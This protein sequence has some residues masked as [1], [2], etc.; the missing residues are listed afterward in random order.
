MIKSALIGFVL[1]F[2]FT[3]SAYSVERAILSVK[4]NHKI[5]TKD[6][7]TILDSSLIISHKNLWSDQEKGLLKSLKLNH[8][9]KAWIVETIG[10]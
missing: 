8:F 9:S 4:Q 2:L 10:T 7:K 3:H 6:L 5:K 1:V